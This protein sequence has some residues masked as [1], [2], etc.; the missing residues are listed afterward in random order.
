VLDWLEGK[1]ALFQED[2]AISGKEF[3]SRGNMATCDLPRGDLHH[4]SKQAKAYFN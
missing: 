4:A 3:R 2:F 1:T